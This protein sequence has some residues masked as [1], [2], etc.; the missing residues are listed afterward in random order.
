MADIDKCT[1]CGASTERV[2]ANMLYDMGRHIIY[3]RCTQCDWNDAP[4]ELHKREPEDVEADTIPDSGEADDIR[5]YNN[6]LQAMYERG[7][8]AGRLAAKLEALTQ[9]AELS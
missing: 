7:Y 5:E 4:F 3:R 1:E 9:E 6:Q 2:H 8:R